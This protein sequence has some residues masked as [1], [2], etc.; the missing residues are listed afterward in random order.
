MTALARTLPFALLLACAPPN[1]AQPY[2]SAEPPEGEAA[3][4][5]HEPES[6]L[7]IAFMGRSVDLEPFLGAFPFREFMP[8]LAHDRLFF[9]ARGERYELRMAALSGSGGLLDLPA[10]EPVVTADWSQ[11]SLWSLHLRTPTELWL[12]ADARND[13][14]MNLWRVELDKPLLQRELVQV[15]FADYVYD[16][17]FSKDEQRIAYLARSGQQAPYR[18]CLRVLD[19]TQLGAAT[20][21]R[22]VVCD[23]PGLTF[24][25]GTPRFSSDGSKV[26]FN[27]QLD[28]DRRRVQI[29][30]AD[31]A[32]KT[33][34]VRPI[35]DLAQPRSEARMLDGWVG[36]Q[37]LYTAD[38][39][40]FADVYAWSSKTR[41]TKRI[42]QGHE[43][44]LGA[45]LLDQGVLVAHGTPAGSTL[46]LVDSKQGG[47]LG[48]ASVAGRIALLE[49]RGDRV[50]WT[51]ESPSLVFE[52]SQARFVA[53]AEAPELQNE[54]L[55]AL[56]PALEQQLVRCN[57]ERVT[58]P[59]AGGL[60]LHAYL[61]RP[62]EPLADAPIAM[63]RSFY[64]G[65]NEWNEYDHI[66]CAAGITV[67][68]PAVRGSDG[69]GRGF[70]ALNDRDLGGREIVDLFE[71][72]RFI[73]AQLGIPAA[74]VGVYGRSHGGYATMRAL[75]W[76]HDDPHFFPFGF[77]LAEAGFSD[78]V[79][80]Y[81]ATNI[82]DWVI[83]EAGDPKVP[84]DLARM[85][86][87]SPIHAVERL[88]VPLFLLHGENDWRV[89]V[90][91]SRA[92]ASEAERLG[93]PVTYLEVAGQGHQVEGDARIVET[94]QARFDF[95]AGAVGA[96]SKS[97]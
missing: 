16:Y 48:S 78:I 17:G 6:P 18:T 35:T 63:V 2:P 77:G 29:V 91:G 38:E 70:A 27:A 19:A 80:F 57:V 84:S 86:E 51:Q 56:A 31:L 53:G 72:G 9:V 12:H 94:W 11:R 7:A 74:R 97:K 76:P 26:Y 68:S 85:K 45:Q 66:L 5:E 65:E 88:D 44:L 64:G 67:V 24:T 40:E 79:A 21:E 25:W 59:G 69:F 15:T 95:I 20:A 96:G 8:A 62:R 93:K 92:F 81:E 22:E 47:V 49:G 23:E 41:K 14:Q 34:K 1:A 28:G 52:L 32:A 13:E 82:P 37:L 50:L 42:Y 39:Q 83:L 87:R 89:P 54:R 43:T 61:L 30:E 33:P 75:T 36:D 3:P 60:S 4:A 73:A 55:V 58:I 71:A 46:E 90:A 10:A